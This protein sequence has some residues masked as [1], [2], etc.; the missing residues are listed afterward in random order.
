MTAA[1]GS[2]V[3][4]DCSQQ[5]LV[6]DVSPALG[7]STPNRTAWAQAALM[8][9]MVLSQSETDVGKLRD[10]V[11]GADWS[12]IDNVDGAIISKGTKYQT[13]QLGFDFDFAAQ[14][15]TEPGVKFSDDGEPSSDQLAKTDST[16]QAA[17]DK[18]YTAASGKLD[19]RWKLV[20]AL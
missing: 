16:T 2:V 19:Y 7:S 15:I 18:V 13:V 9:S 12:S 1:F 6:L 17:L 4:N 10:F 8:W 20:L 3:H 5:A 14:T 11:R